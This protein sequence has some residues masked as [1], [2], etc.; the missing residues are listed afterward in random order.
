VPGPILKRFLTKLLVCRIGIANKLCKEHR[1]EL[2]TILALEHVILDFDLGLFRF[3]L[4]T[5][6]G[7]RPSV[8]VVP[9]VV[10][11]FVASF[12]NCQRTSPPFSGCSHR[13]DGNIPELR[14]IPKLIFLCPW[15]IRQSHQSQSVVSDLPYDRGA[16]LRLHDVKRVDLDAQELGTLFWC[17]QGWS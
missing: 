2:L 9:K 13:G 1:S 5:R 16:A 10:P 15:S 14:S 6:F 3:V 8:P 17:H 11:P 4:S 12:P 7:N